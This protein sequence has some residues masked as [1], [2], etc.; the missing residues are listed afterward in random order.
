M[1]PGGDIPYDRRLFL[2]KNRDLERAAVPEHLKEILLSNI[3]ICAFPNPGHVTP[4]LSVGVYLA[5]LGH[6]VTF[7]TGEIFRSQVEATGLRFAADFPTAAF[8]QQLTQTG[9]NDIVVVRNQ[10]PH[11]AGSPKRQYRFS[12]LAVTGRIKTY[13][14]SCI[15]ALPSE[16]AVALLRPSVRREISTQCTALQTVVLRNKNCDSYSLP[17]HELIGH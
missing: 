14:E 3:L 5:G 12:Y 1:F 7:H 8:E 2:F 17:S 4:M 6:T 13:P 10:Y 16:S 11:K 15:L 9:P